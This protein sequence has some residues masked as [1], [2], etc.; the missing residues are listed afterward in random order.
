[1]EQDIH[2]HLAEQHQFLKEHLLNWMTAFFDDLERQ[3]QTPFYRSVSLLTR[4]WLD[5]DSR[6][7]A[8]MSA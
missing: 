8:S 2:M 3:A 4:C 5:L 1:G 7:L 6:S